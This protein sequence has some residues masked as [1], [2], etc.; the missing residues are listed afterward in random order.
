MHI[1][2]AS[3]QGNEYGTTQTMLILS[4]HFIWFV[5]IAYFLYIQ[6][7]QTTTL[8]PDYQHDCKKEDP[9]ASKNHHHKTHTHQDWH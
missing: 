8:T 7:I 2:F 6:C 3:G 9:Y 1:F 4:F 5:A